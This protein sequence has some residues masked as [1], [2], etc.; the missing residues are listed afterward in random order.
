MFVSVRFESVIRFQDERTIRV[1]TK[2][3]ITCH[4][5]VFV[6]DGFVVRLLR[7][8]SCARNLSCGS[9]GR[10]RVLYVC[11]L[12]HSLT[13]SQ[14]TAVVAVEVRRLGFVASQTRR[15][16][17]AMTTKCAAKDRHRIVGRRRRCCGLFVDAPTTTGGEMCADIA[18]VFRHPNR[19]G[20]TPPTTP[21]RKRQPS[22][23]QELC[24]FVCMEAVCH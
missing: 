18:R 3:A 6:R 7:T 4:S 8:R 10:S 23:V 24:W 15:R 1:H 17:E 22:G 5:M 16:G 12:T 11:A 2:R 14:K 9:N 20:Q 21:P 13:H 19:M